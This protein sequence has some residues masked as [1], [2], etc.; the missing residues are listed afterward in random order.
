MAQGRAVTFPLQL[1]EPSDDALEVLCLGAH[2]DDI[3]IG[4]GGTVLRLVQQ[5]PAARFRWVVL[6]GSDERAA[7]AQ[8]AAE[9]F[10]EGAG[11]QDIRIEQFR[12][13]YFPWVGMEIKDYFETL[14]HD[15]D[16]DLILT[17]HRHDRH[18]DHRM[19]AELTWNT[20]RS[21]LILEYE[22][23]KYDGD[24][25][26][27]NVLVALDES[28]VQRKIDGLMTNFPS[29]RSR[30]WFDTDTFRGLMRL[31]GVEANTRERFAEGFYATKVVL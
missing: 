6:S 17:H 4:C 14:R 20:W 3:E 25:G 11:K 1:H 30:S 29:Q 2:C 9:F 28:I 27:P 12:E 24:M 26:S 23:P 16:P 18:Q 15:V 10:L 22:I 31:R 21:H 7:E 8:R 13:S 19:V 5:F